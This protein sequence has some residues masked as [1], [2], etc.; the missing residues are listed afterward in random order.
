MVIIAIGS[1]TIQ[2][3]AMRSDMVLA[4]ISRMNMACHTLQVTFSGC[5]APVPSFKE[6]ISKT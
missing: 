3:Q 1:K 2:N 5:L 6:N 4:T